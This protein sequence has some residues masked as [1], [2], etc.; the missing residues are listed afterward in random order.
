[1]QCRRP[2]VGSHPVLTFGLQEPAKSRNRLLFKNLHIKIDQC[3]ILMCPLEALW[4]EWY[5]KTIE[6]VAEHVAKNTPCLARLG[7]EKV[8]R[9]NGIIGTVTELHEEHL[10]GDE[11]ADFTTLP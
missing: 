9:P 2:E 11:L 8:N 3:G 5:G 6:G 4:K 1:Q 10:S 7:F